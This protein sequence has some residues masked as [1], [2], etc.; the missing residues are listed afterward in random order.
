MIQAR[1]KELKIKDGAKA[2]FLYSTSV[3]FTLSFSANFNRSA[4]FVFMEDSAT[5][6]FK[7]INAPDMTFEDLCKLFAPL[8]NKKNIDLYIDKLIFKEENSDKSNVFTHLIFKMSSGINF[9]KF[10][11][12]NTHIDFS[13]VTSPAELHLPKI[14]IL[15]V[16]KIRFA[17][18]PSFYYSVPEKIAEPPVSVSLGDVFAKKRFK[19]S[20][21]IL[22]RRYGQ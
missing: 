6:Y 4:R 21:P 10:N 5:Y 8:N 14:T 11:L 9:F 16:K 1:D 17:G 22:R 2:I 18:N 12:Y 15:P 3:P 20:I 7:E 13:A 19:T